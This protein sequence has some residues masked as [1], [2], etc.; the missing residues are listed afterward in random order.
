MKQTFLAL[1][2][3]AAALMLGACTSVAT[4]DYTA[5]S[6][7]MMRFREAGV[8]KK[9]V[10][11]L[12]FMDQ[13]GSGAAQAARPAG[14]HGSLYLGLIPLLPYGWVEKGEPENS[15]DFVSLGRFGFNPQNDLAAAAIASLKTSGLFSNVTKANNIAQ[16]ASADYVW[17][18]TVTSTFYRGRMFSYCISYFF[19]PVLWVVGFPSGSSTNELGVKFE[20][21][22]RVTGEAVWQYEWLDSDYLNHWIYARI[23]KDV[24]LYPEL[25]KRA[26]NSALGDLAQAGLDL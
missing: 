19:S 11:V 5:A 8:A 10:A 13:R 16:A 26:M 20:L 2:F 18:G 25:M 7:T 4:F 12:P 17:R 22:D 9:S 1:A 21:V 6:G 24:S 3:A 15:V 23:G 14:D